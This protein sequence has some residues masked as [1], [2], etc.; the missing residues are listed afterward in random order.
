V[1]H[2]T[3]LLKGIHKMEIV[4]SLVDL[5]TKLSSEMKHLKNGKAA[6]K[7]YIQDMHETPAHVPLIGREVTSSTATPL[8]YPTR[9]LC[10]R[11]LLNLV[12]WQFQ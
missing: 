8:K 6:L 10:P 1:Q 12:P 2:E 7:L 4:S 11:G 9:K 3:V 5:V